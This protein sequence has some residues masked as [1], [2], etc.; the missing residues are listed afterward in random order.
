MRGSIKTNLDWWLAAICIRIEPV[1]CD[2]RDGRK[3]NRTWVNHH[4]IH[5]KTLAEA[6][7]KAVVL[8][9]KSQ[10]RYKARRG[11]LKYRFVG[12]WQILLIHDDIA[13]GE[14]LLWDDYGDIT[15]RVAKRRCQS[16][17]QVLA[18]YQRPFGKVKRPGAKP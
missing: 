3:R 7:D 18:D 15:A 6:Y 16:K 2:P 1:G 10:M 11:W 13:D 12:I 17:R 14:E 4:L 9:K 8:G 5:A